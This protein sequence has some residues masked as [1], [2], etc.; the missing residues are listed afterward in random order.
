MIDSLQAMLKRMNPTSLDIFSKCY[1]ELCFILS[2]IGVGRLQAL[3]ISSAPIFHEELVSLFPDPVGVGL[4]PLHSLTKLTLNLTI[5][6]AFH[7]LT[8]VDAS[9]LEE[10]TCRFRRLDDP[11]DNHRYLL[12]RTRWGVSLPSLRHIHYDFKPRGNSSSVIIRDLLELTPTIQSAFINL[13]YSQDDTVVGEAE[14]RPLLLGRDGTE[15]NLMSSL[16]QQ[17]CG[18]FQPGEDGIPVKDLRN[19]R[20]RLWFCSE[21]SESLALDS[22]QTYSQR[23][24]GQ[25][26]AVLA[27]REVLGAAP[28][29]VV[30]AG[31]YHSRVPRSVTRGIHFHG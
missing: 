2:H 21:L 22:L 6:Q 5:S 10:L 20:L 8:H 31:V 13:D 17:V 7:L 29:L 1:L 16:F 30:D 24:A 11:E 18:I 25:F 15:T 4:Y 14:M 26:S 9:M 19:L 27:S 12:H 28:G 3:E 23:M